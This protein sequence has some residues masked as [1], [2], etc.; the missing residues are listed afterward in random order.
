ML[1]RQSMCLERARSSFAALVKELGDTR[2]LAMVTAAVP[3]VLALPQVASCGDLDALAHRPTLPE[4]SAQRQELR[5]ARAAMAEAEARMRAGHPEQGLTMLEPWAAKVRSL[6]FPPLELELLQSLAGLET[7]TPGKQGAAESTYDQALRL[8]ATLGDD[9][10]AARL[11]ID[12]VGALGNDLGRPQDAYAQRRAAELALSRLAVP[13]N[14][15]RRADLAH[16]LALAAWNSGRAE[17]ALALCREGLT[18]REH[19]LG[20]SHHAVAN[21]L[22]L[23]G[24]LLSE[25]G[26][27]DGSADAHEEALAVRRSA[28]GEHHPYVAD[29]LDNLGVVR[30]Y[31]GRVSEALRLHEQALE[32]RERVLGPEHPDVGT[33]LNN[34]GSLKLELGDHEAASAYFARALSIWEKSLTPGDTSLAIALINLA[35]VALARGDASDARAKCERALSIESAAVEPDSPTLAW[36]YTCLGEV[37]TLEKHGQKA[38]PL[39]EKAL[40]LRAQGDALERA[41][42]ELSLAEAQLLTRT[43][44]KRARGLAEGAARTFRAAGPLGE[45]RLKRA[46][47]LL[48]ALNVR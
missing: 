32:L 28:L 23:L 18:I 31:Q 40:S 36:E 7:T 1:D 45:T 19:A 47:R 2:E 27:F 9:T 43:D 48:K 15:P 11:W 26:D 41:R 4:G 24:I 34:V 3:S 42:T 14:D 12:L 6:R 8:A 10:S 17:E 38:L 25:R 46:E 16:N 29:S 33:S 30:Q 22:N 5:R 21:S 44:L 20:K 39:L 35:D 13:T 37:E